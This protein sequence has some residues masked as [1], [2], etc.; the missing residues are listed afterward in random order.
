MI[1]IDERMES[2]GREKGMQEREK[3]RIGPEVDYQ[4]RRIIGWSKSVFGKYLG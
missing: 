4:Y 3:E 1:F 2:G